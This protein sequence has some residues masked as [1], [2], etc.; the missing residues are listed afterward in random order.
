MKEKKYLPLRI[1]NLVFIVLGLAICILTI[2]KANDDSSTLAGLVLFTNM[3]ALVVSGLYVFLG[4]KKNAAS[5]YKLTM[6]L[7]T[8]A[9]ALFLVNIMSTEVSSVYGAVV[10]VLSLVLMV[11]IA[12]AKDFGEKN[13]KII[14]LLLILCR[15]FS[16]VDSIILAPDLGNKLFAVLSGNL[17]NLIF[18][19]TAGLMIMGKY[20]DK[21]NRGT[22]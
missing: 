21:E 3:V 13:T 4:Y 14:L 2:T 6:A 11:I 18:A 7:L 10:Q 8:F 17:N 5:Y 20:I 22:K 1:L 19:S 9:Q 15:T 16:L 12:S